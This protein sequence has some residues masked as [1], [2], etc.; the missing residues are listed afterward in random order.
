MSDIL[1]RDL[2]DGIHLDRTFAHLV[3]AAHPDM[4]AFP[5]SNATS[6]RPIKYTFSKPLSENHGKDASR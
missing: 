1:N 2:L 3:T 5:D 4:Q 6:D